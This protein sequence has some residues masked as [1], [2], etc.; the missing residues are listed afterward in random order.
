MTRE[1]FAVTLTLQ[2]GYAFSIDFGEQLGAP[3][4]VDE[5][6]PLG[7]GRGPNPARV[8]AAAVGSC[9]GASLLFCLRKAHV[10]PAGLRTTVETTMI[11]NARGRLRIGKIDVHLSPELAAEQRERIGRCVELFEDFCI[12]TES[13]RTGI[14]VNVTVDGVPLPAGESATV[15]SIGA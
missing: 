3:L 4:V 1:Q 15:G 8:L 14:D 5:L 9:L 11:R 10:E 13:V 2:D 6:P 7:K 12:V